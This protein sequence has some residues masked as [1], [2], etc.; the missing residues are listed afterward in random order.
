MTNFFNYRI[1]S[2]GIH[3]ILSTSSMGKLLKLKKIIS[4]IFQSPEQLP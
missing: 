1:D 3:K 4:R 2:S